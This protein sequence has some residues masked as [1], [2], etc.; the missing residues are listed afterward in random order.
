MKRFSI[1]F[2]LGLVVFLGVRLAGAQQQ[3]PETYISELA[4]ELNLWR[5]TSNLGPL[6]PNPTLEAMAAAQ[7]DYLISLPDIPQGG[8]IHTGAKGEDVRK[9]SQFP[10]FA[11]PTYGHPDRFSV[12]EIAGIGSVRSSM[13]FWQTSSLHTRSV[14]NPLYREIGIAARQLKSGDLLFIVVMG[15]RPD[16]LPAMAD[17]EVDSLY[18]T[19]ERTEWAGDWMGQATRYRL[20]NTRHQPLQDWAPW[21]TIVDLPEDAERSFFVEYEDASGHRAENEVLL[22]PRWS[23]LGASAV[24]AAVEPTTA[25]PAGL[26]MA[27]N[28]PAAPLV[29]PTAIPQPTLAPTTIPGAINLIY[30]KGVLTVIS[31]SANADLSDL[32]FRGSGAQ[33]D[34]VTWEQVVGGLNIGALPQGHCLQVGLRSL[35]DF[36][37][38]PGCNYL[39]SIVTVGDDRQFWAGESFEVLVGDIIVASCA[40]GVGQCSIPLP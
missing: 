13:N 40:A 21:E 26:V 15:A 18:L 1:A 2:L 19:T 31:T 17:P 23:S 22:Y 16:V 9:R 7:A 29:L 6:L 12:T 32:H 5:V 30:Y 10:Q 39:R 27:A 34:A 33:F 3:S 25:A 37:P 36:S 24:P 11:W 20:L 38:P 8:D 35:G 4:S 14:T 28:T